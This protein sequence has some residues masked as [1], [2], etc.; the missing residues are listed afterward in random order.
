VKS[1]VSTVVETNSGTTTIN[2]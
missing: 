1:E 2:T